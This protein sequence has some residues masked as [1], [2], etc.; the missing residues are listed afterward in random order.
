[1]YALLSGAVAA[2]ACIAGLAFLRSYLRTRDRFFIYFAGAF[3]IFGLTQIML[4]VTNTPELNHPLS[5]IPRLIASLLI[6]TAIWDKNR[7]VRS[8]RRFEPPA[9][10]DAYQRR[11]IAR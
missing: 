6:L 11:R 10:I 2:L 7:T 5:Y 9:E 1:M 4:G 3:V 8:Q